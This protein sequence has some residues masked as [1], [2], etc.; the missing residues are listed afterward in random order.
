VGLISYSLYLWHWPLLAYCQYWSF[1]EPGGGFRTGLLAA[2]GVLAVLSWKYVETPIRRRLMLRSRP[3]IFGFAAFATLL[4]FATG[5]LIYQAR[6]FPSRIPDY[7][8]RFTDGR[9]N[10]FFRVES[11]VNDVRTGQFKDLGTGGTAA[12]GPIRLLLWG[13]SHAMSLA[14]VIDNLCRGHLSKGFLAAH[15][16]TAPVLGYCSLGKYSLHE[17]S[18]HFNDAVL[19][20]IASNHTPNVVIAAFWSSY[21]RGDRPHAA[22]F[23]AQL[24]KTV[25][26]VLDA[27][28]RVYVIKD[29]PQPGFDVPHYITLAEARGRSLDTLGET[30]KQ[31]QLENDDLEDTFDQISRMGATVLDPK[32]YFLINKDFYGVVKNGDVLYWDAHHLTVEGANMLAPLFEPIF[33]KN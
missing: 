16:S 7:N 26:A 18:P 1:E 27:G 10:D 12:D 32:D 3:Q 28:A 8:L 17:K 33:G 21:L 15:S 5:F 14:L 4:L 19:N 6:G 2:S 11:T 9:T 25:R 30:V 13:D 22:F 20:Y 29:V 31:Y 24:L 23:K